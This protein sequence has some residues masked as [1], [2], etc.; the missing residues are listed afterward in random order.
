MAG[1][2]LKRVT[3]GQPVQP[4]AGRENALTEAALW[5]RDQQIVSRAPSFREDRGFDGIVL[6]KNTTSNDLPRGSILALSDVV[7]SPTVNLVEYYRRVALTGVAPT[8]DDSGRFCIFMEPVNKGAVGRAWI[9]GTPFVEIDVVDEDHKFCEVT[10]ATERLQSATSGSA[11]ILWKESG[12]GNK[13][14][15]VR[16]GNLGTT[17]PGSV[18]NNNGTLIVGTTSTGDTTVW[19]LD[20]NVVWS[21]NIMSYDSGGINDTVFTQSLGVVVISGDGRHLVTANSAG[22]I[23]DDLAIGYSGS[24]RTYG[25]GLAKTADGIYYVDGTG[26][27]GAG[28]IRMPD[29]TRLT[30]NPSN[31]TDGNAVRVDAAGYIA[32][33]DDNSGSATSFSHYDPS[34]TWSALALASA[35]FS[36]SGCVGDID[37]TTGKLYLIGSAAQCVVTMA[38]NSATSS[39]GIGSTVTA[40]WI[41]PWGGTLYYAVGGSITATTIGTAQPQLPVMSSVGGSIN[42]MVGGWAN[43]R[44]YAVIASGSGIR[45]VDAGGIVWSKTGNYKSCDFRGTT[46]SY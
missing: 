10:T 29:G 30:G 40:A 45:L 11:Q 37:I 43:G 32:Q 22:T 21:A 8:A 15:V 44:K 28:T 16:L 35:S 41:P 46:P 33:W 3:T 36:S 13:K 19:D 39:A 1:D 20:G 26:G 34:G 14:A 42:K 27:T 6:V 9:D 25:H 38:T 18:G 5:V 12:T 31:V 17:T 4:S 2:P 24:G 23:T 7:I